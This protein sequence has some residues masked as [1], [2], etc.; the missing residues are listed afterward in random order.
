MRL[1]Y[2]SWIDWIPIDFIS[3]GVGLLGGS[4]KLWDRVGNKGISS[5]SILLCL[6]MKL[7]LSRRDVSDECPPD[8][9]ARFFSRGRLLYYCYS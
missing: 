2:G 4:I 5:P 9:K 6:L 7:F 1:I 3:G 8:S